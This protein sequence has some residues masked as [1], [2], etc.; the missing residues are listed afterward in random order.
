LACVALCSK[1]LYLWLKEYGLTHVFSHRVL[2]NLLLG[3]YGCV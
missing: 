2:S 1:P 3:P